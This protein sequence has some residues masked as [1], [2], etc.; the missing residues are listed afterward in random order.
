MALYITFKHNDGRLNKI[1]W[2]IGQPSLSE[3]FNSDNVI[4]VQADGDE[5][6]HINRFMLNLPK[7]IIKQVVTWKDGFARFIVDNL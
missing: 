4:S 1:E 5:L 6:E 2:H 7:C 3:L